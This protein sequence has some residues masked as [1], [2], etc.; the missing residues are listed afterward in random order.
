MRATLTLVLLVIASPAWAQYWTPYENARF[1]YEIDAPP[2]FEGNGE[3]AN[4]DGQ[5]FYNYIAAQGLSVWGGHFSEEF[6]TEA[7]AALDVVR[8]DNWTI[9]SQSSTPH[10]AE[11]VAQRD[12]RMLRQRMIML[13]DGDSYAA[14]RLEFNRGDL[15][16]LEPIIAGLQRSFKASDC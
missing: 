13:C 8:A 3:S 4:G 16:G 12:E 7:A 11:F 14:L 15:A 6:E 1:G 10:W 2:G 9:Q 5:I